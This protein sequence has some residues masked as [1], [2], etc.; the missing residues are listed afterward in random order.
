MIKKPVGRPKIAKELKR[1]QRKFYLNENEF[2]IVKEFVKC[3]KERKQEEKQ[4]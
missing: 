3:L 4:N 2:K 1:V